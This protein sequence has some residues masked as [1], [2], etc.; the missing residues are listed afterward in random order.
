MVY[1][2]VF[3]DGTT[4]YVRAAVP[5]TSFFANVRCEDLARYSSNQLDGFFEINI[6]AIDDKFWFLKNGYFNQDISFGVKSDPNKSMEN[7]IEITPYG[8]LTKKVFCIPSSIFSY[9]KMD[10]LERLLHVIEKNY[11]LKYYEK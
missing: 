5:G 11:Q 4:V 7:Y 6:D 9:E 1:S 10:R 8:G 3:I 2:I